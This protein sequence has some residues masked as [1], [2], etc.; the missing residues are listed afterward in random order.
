MS[1]AFIQQ[2]DHP[3]VPFAR[4][5]Q[6]VIL[7]ADDDVVIR[8]MVTRLL[9]KE[10]HS[11][12]SCADGHESLELSRAYP[13]RIDACITDDDMPQLNGEDLCGQ[14]REERPEIKALVMFGHDRNDVSHREHLLFLHKPFNIQ[15]LLARVRTM[16]SSKDV[17]FVARGEPSF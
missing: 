7:V 3:D 10:G 12:L 16:I 4:R 8:N 11:V 1:S 17:G 9:E 2:I 15:T 14:L 5:Q 6:A 13:G